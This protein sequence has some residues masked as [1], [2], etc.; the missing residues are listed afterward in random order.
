YGSV[1]PDGTLDYDNVSIVNP[2]TTRAQTK[3]Y[4]EDGRA[5]FL[6]ADSS[7]ANPDI[8]GRPLGSKDNFLGTGQNYENMYFKE[9]QYML[10][11]MPPEQIQDMKDKGITDPR[12]Y[13]KRY[14][15]MART[16][17]R[18][19]GGLIYKK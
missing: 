6:H 9:T 19:D 13:Q 5:Y 2:Q 11:K 8:Y 7:R 4:P 3:D 17:M 1:K 14:G 15:S 10:S 16:P 18:R 12:D